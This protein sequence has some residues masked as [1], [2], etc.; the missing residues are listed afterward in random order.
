MFSHLKQQWINKKYDTMDWIDEKI[1]HPP[2]SFEAFQQA[3]EKLFKKLEKHR[4]RKPIS[5]KAQALGLRLNAYLALPAIAGLEL[6]SF[7]SK[8]SQTLL[9]FAD[10]FGAKGNAQSATYV[11][12]AVTA[13]VGLSACWFNN[14]RHFSSLWN[15]EVPEEK[16]KS[17]FIP[18]ERAQHAIGQWIEQHG[19]LGSK[20]T[21]QVLR[22]V[23]K[24]Q[25]LIQRLYNQVLSL[26]PA[27]EKHTE[28][29]EY[30][31]QQR[32]LQQTFSSQ[33]L[34][35]HW[36]SIAQI[37]L[38]K[39]ERNQLQAQTPTVETRITTQPKPRRL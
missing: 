24:R 15:K 13:A 28:I 11:A 35:Q 7:L 9:T 12:V 31:K 6:F 18:S 23:A 26:D 16:W 5:F 10:I 3:E 37:P 19:K 25:K 8:E 22:F 33:G 30:L 36:T 17:S 1:I 21:S 39:R 29:S 32:V 14:F 34:D 38:I 27:D 2:M 4:M 20:E